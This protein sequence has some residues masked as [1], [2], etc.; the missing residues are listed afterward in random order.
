[1]S[2]QAGHSLSCSRRTFSLAG[3]ACA[4]VAAASAPMRAAQAMGLPSGATALP[5]SDADAAGGA[6]TG[7]F[8]DLPAD[9][10]ER[11]AALCSLFQAQVEDFASV[12]GSSVENGDSSYAGAMVDLVNL[13][14]AGLE[15]LQAVY[16]DLSAQD[17]TPQVE[18]GMD[19]CLI[20]A[21][22]LEFYVGYYH[23]SDPL[24][25]MQAQ[26]AQG[27]YADETELLDAMYGALGEVRDNYQ[28]LDLPAYMVDLW[29]HY[30]DQI[31]AYQEKLYADYVS[32]TRND[33]LM[34]F[35]AA[36]LLAR[37][38][39]IMLHYEQLMYS[40]MRAQFLNAADTLAADVE[41]SGHVLVEH[42]LADEIFPNLYPS[43]DSVANVAVYTDGSERDVLV[44]VQVDG[45]SQAYR[46]KL[47]ATPEMTYLMIKPPVGS[48]A[49]NLTSERDAQLTLTVTDLAS[50]GLIAQET[51]AVTL[52]SL[53]DFTL[54]SSEFGIVE[55]YNVLAWMRPDAQEVLEVRRAAID[56]LEANMGPDYNTL[57]GYQLGYPED[58]RA[59]T[60]LI[61]ATAIQ[62]A[63]SDMGVRY[64]MGPYSFGAQQRVL[65]PDAVVRSKSGICI[66]TA[67]LVASVLQSADMHPMVLI[68]PGHAQVALE[69][70]E[71]S[72]QYVLLET[73]LL[74]F[75]G[76]D[77]QVMQYITTM[78]ND[79]WESYLADDGTY[80]I[81]CDLASVLGIRGLT[82]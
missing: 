45:F 5:G 55:P 3:F 6:S 59:K 53:Y 40:L 20:V 63:I 35:S 10:L 13:C 70:W 33:A 27:A 54:E 69:T 78:P 76:A 47:T 9:S 12:Y 82:L 25:E 19:V 21:R 42:A 38:P 8:A 75:T 11:L 41:A 34:A 43:A 58:D 67:L 61:Q 66:E 29:P 26:A 57:P 68:L 79:E 80:V 36:W 16:V 46:Q 18:R 64:N 44:E 31:A 28:S 24:M 48:D 77:G 4:A 71:G 39:Y 81:D 7:P 60:V 37:Q 50:G 32:I 51:Q 23:S 30:I 52:H 72:G 17:R 22:T 49:G 2:N 65:T 62:G 15:E 1:M 56:W 73:T 14:S 74:P